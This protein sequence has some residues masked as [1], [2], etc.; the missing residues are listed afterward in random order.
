MDAGLIGD[1][2]RLVRRL[3]ELKFL[4]D[5]ALVLATHGHADHTGG[6]AAVRRNGPGQ[7]RIAAHAAAAPFVEAGRNAPCR[8]ATALGYLARP[9][10]AMMPRSPGIAVDVALR[11]EVSLLP[12]GVEGTIAPTPGHTLGCVS[13]VLPTGEAVVGDL[14]MTALGRGTLPRLPLFTQDVKRWKQSVTG[15]L[16]RGIRTFHAAHG[17]PF[18]ASQVR[19]LLE[20]I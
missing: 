2:D 8:P 17:G 9:F 3:A 11:D 15:L 7:L 19:R 6:L 1:G 16:D 14:L 12:Y 13:I 10:I 5:L 18:S 20:R 4:D